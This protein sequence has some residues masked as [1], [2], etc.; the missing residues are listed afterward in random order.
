MSAFTTELEVRPLPDGKLWELLKGFSY[1][2]DDGLLVTAPT[3]FVTDFAST[4][5]P[6]WW[7][8]P[9]WGK[10]G[11]AA[12]IHDLGYQLKFWSRGRC[13]DEYRK[14]MAILGVDVRTQRIMYAFL[15]AFGWIA[16]RRKPRKQRVEMFGSA[17]IRK[18]VWTEQ[19]TS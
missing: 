14:G 7:L 4:P 6:L 19:P 15:R 5:R 11:K 12:V 17:L 8:Y 13:D 3:G 18:R 9:P 16:W 2:T 10:Y 1:Y